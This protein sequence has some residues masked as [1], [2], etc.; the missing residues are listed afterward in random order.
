ME[1]ETLKELGIVMTE[2][3]LNSYAQAQGINATVSAMSEQEKVA[4]RYKFVLDQLSLANGDFAKTSDGWANQ[5]RIMQLRFESFK[6]TIGQGLINIFLPIVKVLNA[7]IARLQVFAQYFSAITGALFGKAKA[8]VTK[9]SNAISSVSSSLGNAGA[10]A[11]KALKK[12]SNATKKTGTAAK[13]AKKEIKGL[14]G[15]L[16]EINNLSSNSTA[17]TSGSSPSTSSP[18]TSGIGGIGSLGDIGG[19]GDLDLGA[20]IDTSGLEAKAE[21]I[22]AVFAKIRKVITKNKDAIISIM[23]GITAAIGIIV[24]KNWSSITSVLG[25]NFPI[26]TKILSK[27]LKVVTKPLTLIKTAI[28]GLLGLNPVFL[29]IAVAIAVVV[30]S[31]TYLWRTN[32]DFRNNIIKTWV[33]IKKALQPTL[34]AFGILFKT[35]ADIVG[36][37]LGGAFKIVSKIILKVVEVFVGDF[38]KDLR[39]F[40]PLI[41]GIGKVFLKFAKDLQRDWK[42]IK[43]FS[44]KKWL[45][46]KKQEVKEGLKVI[47]T[48]FSN[49]GKD[50]QK[51][52]NEALDL[53]KDFVINIAS[54]VEDFKDK[55]SEKWN[56]AKDWIKDKALEIGA[57]VADFYET[58]QNKLNEAK[59]WL[60]D[61]ALEIGAKV[62]SFYNMAKDN[63]NIAKNNIKTWFLQVGAKVASFYD[64]VKES[65]NTAKNNIKTWLFSVG[66]KVGSFYDKVKSA[67]NSAKNSI[68]SWAF[69]VALKVTSSAS[70]IKSTVNSVIRSINNNLLAK[71]KIKLPGVLGGGTWSVPKIPYLAKG[72]IVDSATLS[73]IGEAGKEAVIPLEN[74]TRGLDLLATKLQSR[75]STNNI[76]SSFSGSSSNNQGI[77]K[78]D[79]ESIGPFTFN[80]SIGGQHLRNITVDTLRQLKRQG[81][82]I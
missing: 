17:G 55:V 2:N 70:A 65:F 67:Y 60:R 4:L 42:K 57:K 66:V 33:N 29:A 81:I 76:S 15:G 58:V 16:D 5:V 59:N 1:T 7:V 14:I 27:L 61:K 31:L 41:K 18:Y 11:S 63:F 24:I 35:L 28:K 79:L 30:S 78:S 38:M 39:G 10:N 56:A 43:N 25:K 20:G 77:T 45:D 48:Y 73:V 22:A 71:L 64:K 72:G 80:I 12:A 74:N 3:A 19:L 21:K 32:K 6:A 36:T 82:T 9:V 53:V 68:K 62:G 50:I 46:K 37:V 47:T 75:M 26:L 13:K 40:I 34:E 51:K 8:G 44:A 23:A 69:S 52:W 49:L 54:I